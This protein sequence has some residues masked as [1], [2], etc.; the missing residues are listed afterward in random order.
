GLLALVRN[1][2]TRDRYG[3]VPHMPALHSAAQHGHARFAAALIAAGAPVEH[4]RYSETALQLAVREGHEE[5]VRELLSAVADMNTENSYVYSLLYLA[6]CTNNERMMDVLFAAGEEI[7]EDWT[8][9]LNLP[10]QPLHAAAKKGFCRPLEKLFQ[11]GANINWVDSTGQTALHLACF[12][13]HEDAVE[14]LLRHNAS[15]T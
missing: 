5:V 7:G 14:V 13:N 8:D 12:H 6:V 11:A 9:K 2:L 15:V 4:R 1:D 10:R 3:G